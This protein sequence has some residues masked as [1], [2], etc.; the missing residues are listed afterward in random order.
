MRRNYTFNLN[1]IHLLLFSHRCDV[2]LM[3]TD[4]SVGSVELHGEWPRLDA[5]YETE[6]HEIA[7]VDIKDRPL[8]SLDIF[9]SDCTV[10]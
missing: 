10:I 7:G 9:S 4:A 2:V 6:I 8:Q 5:S 1:F 3:S